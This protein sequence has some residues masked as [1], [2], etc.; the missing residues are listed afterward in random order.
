MNT[1]K[2][3]VAHPLK[4][5]SFQTAMALKEA[6]MLEK[7]ITTVY[8][9]DGSLTKKVLPF[10]KGNTKKKAE[11]R[12]CPPLDND[13]KQVLEFESLAYLGM[14]RITKLKLFR[15]W[16]IRKVINRFGIKVAKYAIKHNVDAVIMYDTT[17]TTCF[18]YLKKHAPYIKRVLDVSISTG[19]F[20]KDNFEK[21][22]LLTGDEGHR[23][24]SEFLWNKTVMLDRDREIESSQYFLAASNIV[25]KS[26][27]YCGAKEEQI[28]IIPY[29]V[30]RKKFSF[31]PK[32]EI[33]GTLK[34]VF[35]GQV[36]YR[37]GIHHICKVAK[38]MGNAVELFLA[39][40]FDSESKIY[41][42]YK[43]CDNIHFCGFV[44]RDKLAGLYNDC[45]VFVF[46]TLGEG[47]GLVILE[48]LSC[49]VPCIV[50]NLAGGDDAIVNG[51]NGFVFNA[52]DDN[53]LKKK[54]E[55]FI[56]HP[57]EIERMSYASRKSV[58]NLTWD[59]YHKA[60]SNTLSK[61]INKEVHCE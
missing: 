23:E 43:N 58:E 2:V 46:P 12:S 44:T 34:L 60:V 26:L 33:T 32:K 19:R 37:K 24:E 29:G 15:R 30:D 9:K 51:E 41:E 3:L 6:G 21:D 57:G 54:I 31:V 14:Q 35:V 56:E 61:I 11:S 42:K 48:A 39:G 20:M 10:L 47:Y 7:Y 50:S 45:D 49:G 22:M 55:W 18:E 28:Y 27:I 1:G 53:E 17:A 52:G 5:H 8:V 36:N 16:F 40:P 59:A 38:E 25:K 4:Q 13:V